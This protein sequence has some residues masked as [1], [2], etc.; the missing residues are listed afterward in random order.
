MQKDTSS[1]TGDIPIFV[2]FQ[3]GSKTTDRLTDIQKV[4]LFLNLN[5][6]VHGYLI[7]NFRVLASI[8]TDIFNFLLE[9]EREREIKGKRKK[10]IK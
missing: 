3:Y 4:R 9:R 5:D 6:C 10:G 1:R 7:Q 8:L 2:L